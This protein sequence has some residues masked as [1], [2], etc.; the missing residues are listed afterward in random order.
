MAKLILTV[1][2]Q[3]LS[4]HPVNKECLTIGRRPDNDIHIDNPVVS[5]QH[6]Q[7]ITIL[8][9]SFIEDLNSTNGTLINNKKITK[10]ALA[11]GDVIM[12]GTHHLK[13]V[14]ELASTAA[15]SDDFEKTMVINTGAMGMPASVADQQTEETM[16]QIS[17]AMSEPVTESLPEP[18]PPPLNLSASLKI[19]SGSNAGK[20]LEL[21]KALTTLGKPGAQVA[22]ISKRP[23][24]YSIINVESGEGQP[25]MVNGEDI[26][27][28][29]RPLGNN[30]IIE[31]AGIRME[32][33][34]S[35]PE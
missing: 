20:Q 21:T 33:I 2:D 19:L 6:C 23:Q 11:N 13:Y 1:E 28:G 7:I 32:F 26:G 8:N 22:A 27:K 30:D 12:L 25:P 3:V 14:N 9:D 18:T 35:S 4:E 24:G 16:E 17:A 34:L 10:H 5:G 31:V 29:M 15:S